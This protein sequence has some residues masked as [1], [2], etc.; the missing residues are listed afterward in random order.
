MYDPLNHDGW[1]ITA[2]TAADRTVRSVRTDLLMPG[3]T[4]SYQTKIQIPADWEGRKTLIAQIVAVTGES[5]LSNRQTAEELL[6]IG[7]SQH[8]STAQ[9]A[10]TERLGSEAV[11]GI[12]TDAHDL[13]LSA[14]LFQRSGEDY[15][16]ITIRNRS[17][18]NNS[19]VTPILSA[20]YRDK[21]LYSYTFRNPMG[22]DFGYSMD[23]P[24]QTLMNGRYLP[25]LDLYVSNADYE[26]FADSD[27]HV[28]LLLAVQ[29]CIVDQPVNVSAT[30]GE[31]AVF[32]VTVGG[33]A[34]PCR[35]QWQCKTGID[36]WADI[37]GADQDTYRITSVRLKQNGLTV[38]CVITDQL[39]NSVTSDPAVLSV[40][41][42]LC[43][44]DQPVS[45]TATEGEEAVFFVTVDGGAKPCRY[46]WQRMTGND[47]WT[48]IPGA[49]QDTYRIA[50][51]QLEQ[52]GLTV[53]CVITDQL[54]NSVTSDPAA[55]SVLPQPQARSQLTLWLLLAI[56]SAAVLAIVFY[57]KRRK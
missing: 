19:D 42:Q 40:L 54:G 25:E 49:D 18:N 9:S 12:D 51:T 4:H 20:S 36:Q 50:S 10:P 8:G 52:N 17:G 24:L 53:R 48:D 33:G 13:M 7:A 28:R 26:D 29:L 31:E 32:S 37:P 55:L 34:K 3:D 41:P 14:Q 15:V 5:A 57:K 23:I 38:R 11:K 56:S 43:I 35:Y 6:L 21:I 46:Q 44:V 39:G 2:A 27:N 22:D 16:H 1:E 45:I 30:E 47:Q